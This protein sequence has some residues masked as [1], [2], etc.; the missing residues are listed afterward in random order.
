MDA[1]RLRAQLLQHIRAFFAARDVLE[2]DT[3]VLSHFTVTAPHLASFRT[4][5]Q[6]AAPASNSPGLFLQTSP[7][8]AMKRLLAAGSGDIFQIS[9][10]F[11][12]GEAG[13]L[14][15]PEFTLIEWY[16]TDTSYRALMSEVAELVS[17]LF[18]GLEME[19]EPAYL[20][21]RDAFLQYVDIDPFS[22]SIDDL[23]R[24]AHD[25]GVHID[26]ELE[27]DAW[28]DVVM[29]HVVEPALPRDR[30]VFIYD[31]PPSQAALAQLRHD[32]PPVAERF[33]LYVRGV[34]LANGYQELTD[35]QEQRQRFT[36]DRRY[37]SEH[38]LAPV[39]ADEHLLAALEHGLP[40][41]SG[42]ALGFDRLAMLVAGADSIA[43]VL[44][45]PVERC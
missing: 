4:V 5:V 44:A 8:Y 26:S 22:A 14:H 33:E 27:K 30:L 40:S 34:E 17:S 20:R 31:F 42:V 41:V 25:H 37:R 18:A 10:A 12:A 43:Q 3:P 2:V 9:H 29:T 39:D 24:T 35:A 45:F 28:L 23:R 19:S 38:G 13:R 1:L 36:A 32:A 16:R 6:E 15:N 21:Y 11:R 7:E